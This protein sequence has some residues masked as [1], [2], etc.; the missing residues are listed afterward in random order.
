MSDGS[1]TLAPSAMVG[2]FCRLRPVFD[3]DYGALYQAEYGSS[4]R[5]HGGTPTPPQYVEMLWR[6]VHAQFIVAPKE[7]DEVLG[8]VA[9]YNADLQNG[10]CYALMMPVAGGPTGTARVLEGM[11]LLLD[12]LFL[13]LP[14]RK[15]YFEADEAESL[16]TAARVDGLVEE[17][18][19]RR[20]MFRDGEYVDLV[21][22]ALYRD[23]WAERRARL[24]GYS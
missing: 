15:V 4:W 17:G 12:H 22:F 18:R 5:L 9:A 8:L 20:H 14:L 24:R 2:R 13:W 3:S 21:T 10:H 11:A 19:L 1:K 16:D 6:N 23:Q 7:G